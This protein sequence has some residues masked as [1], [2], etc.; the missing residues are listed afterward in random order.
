MNWRYFFVCPVKSCMF[1][2]VFLCPYSKEDLKE[3]KVS[4]NLKL[5]M[6]MSFSNQKSI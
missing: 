1:D 5:D 6:N 3:I 2:F 4:V